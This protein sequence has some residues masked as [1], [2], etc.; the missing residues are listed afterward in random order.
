MRF[1]DKYSGIII[2]FS[3]LLVLLGVIS[4][5]KLPNALLPDLDQQEIAMLINWQGKTATEIEQVLIIPLERQLA[6]IGQLK[7]S[8]SFISN[9]E[10]WMRL[11]FQSQTD[12]EKAYMDVM[13][14]INQIPDWPAQVAKP[15]IFDYSN[16]AGSTVA[17]MYLYS[18]LEELTPD[19][20]RQAYR[21]HIASVLSNVSG[22]ANINL[23][24]SPLAQR[25]DIEF[26]PK[27][28]TRFSL[29][30]DDVTEKL[31]DLIDR[32]GDKMKLGS[33]AYDLHFKGQMSL[34]ELTQLPVA[35]SGERI[36]RL[37]EL[38][39]VHKRFVTEWDYSSFEGHP[40]MYFSFQ[41]DKKTNALDIT[42][43]LSA[44]MTELNQGALAEL[45]MK[46]SFRANTS[47][48]IKHALSLVYTNILLGVLLACLFLYVFI[49]DLK[50]V[51]LIFVSI[52]VCLSLVILG[53]YFGGR[54]LN[55]ISL[56]GMA[57]SVGLLLDASIIVM[58]NIQRL[59]VE[60]L[61]LTESLYQGVKQVRGALISSTLSSIVIFVPIV[62]MQSSTSQLFEDLAYTISS[63]LIASILVALLLLPALGRRVLS[64]HSHMNDAD[65]PLSS[66]K[67]WSLRLTTPSRSRLQANIWVGL[68]VV[69]ALM[70]TWWV[71]PAIDLLPNPKSESVIAYV[72]FKEPLS[73]EA[74]VEQ[75][76]YVIE[77][78]FA[79][80]R[81]KPEAPA[82]TTYILSCN[83]GY[84]YLN[85]RP[86][87]G[88]DYARFEQWLETR[89][90]NDLPDTDLYIRQSN[91][92]GGAI[93]G[94]DRSRVDLKGLSLAEL[95]QAGQALKDIIKERIAGS[96]VLETV[97][98]SN[99]ATQ[100][101]FTPKADKLAYL[102]LS[103]A[104][105]NRYL[106]ALTDGEYLG[107][108]S[109]GNESFPFYFK[110]QEVEHIEQ[111]LETELMIPNH[112]LL[113]LRDLVDTQMVL[114]PS[115]IFRADNEMT[116]SLGV[117]PPNGQPMGPFVDQVKVIVSEYIKEQGPHGLYVAYQGQAGELDSFLKE[118]LLTFL[119]SLLVLFLLMRIA[120][121]SWLFAIAVMS[122]MPLAIAGGMLGLNVL[123]L[124]MPQD[125]D[126]IT[127]IGFIILMGLVINNAILLVGEFKTGMQEG[128]TQQVAIYR[129]VSMR[130]R[131]IFMS[132]GTSIFGMLPLMLTPGDGAEI[133]RGLAGVIVGGMTFSALFTLGFMSA[134]LSLPVFAIKPEEQ[135]VSAV[136]EE[137]LVDPI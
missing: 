89:I 29:S 63:A 45:G 104:D 22:I 13:A 25:M 101:E 68:G 97:A 44:V 103:R 132:T 28:L 2:A 85:L 92:L 8:Q 39:K 106:V 121:G 72:D 98:L 54:S 126:V 27:A 93:Q 12:M 47:K 113:P 46:L 59:R 74:A 36:I 137:E 20:F 117:V 123:N 94:G 83:P 1:V 3:A 55:V 32:S 91:L 57:L 52:P 129:A 35:V 127:M 119:V 30:I 120:L 135:K 114:A 107:R 18:E 100:I 31:H 40:A 75:V 67:K 50:V 80:E 102:G 34:T 131:P 87:E 136:D 124:F 112:G 53:M 6:S 37:G 58:E 116:I 77:A 9:G 10:T 110:G 61:N 95:Q 56:A 51:F 19:D 4:S 66:R 42:D 14:R 111:L 125:L 109:A 38:A 84:C 17:S 64:S 86:S 15:L 60:G 105:L 108:F 81:V 133:Y 128:S 99:N 118:F 49:R 71:M 96:Q 78:R 23:S 122:S 5:L 24:H 69:G 82:L 88:V 79:K 73:Q 33:K 41:P 90:L 16:G 115:A 76:A 11:F 43:E 7:H 26:D 48:P 70:L 65:K 134:L 130:M 62:L 21:A